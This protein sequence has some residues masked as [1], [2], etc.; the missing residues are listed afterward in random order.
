MP[1]A[2]GDAIFSMR[3]GE[4]RGP[5]TSESGFHIVRLD[6]IVPGGPLPL[7][8]VRAELERELR[9]T[10]G[11]TAFR[12]KERAVSDALFEATDLA[13]VAQATG[14]E[15]LTAKDYT[16]T[17]GEPFGSNQAAID[18]VF[19]PRVLR[20]GGISDIIE[21]DANRSVVLHVTR[22]QEAMRQSLAEVRDQIVE[23]VRAR[24]GTQPRA[25][26]GRIAASL[27]PRRRSVC[28]CRG[29]R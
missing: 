9:D 20:D 2:L 25:G 17:G 4:I 13:T 1:G 19:D 10:Y 29:C 15:V 6:A 7:D 26:S 21:I 27:A 5:V 18:A 23:S 12:E 14:M 8:Q 16:R 3:E 28:N 24:K 11:D 22:H